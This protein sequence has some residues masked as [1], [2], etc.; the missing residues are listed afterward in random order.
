[1]RL[2]DR[3]RVRDELPRPPVG[4]LRRVVIEHVTGCDNG[5]RGSYLLGVPEKPIED[6]ILHDIHLQQHPS[7]KP[8]TKGDEFG[9]MRGVYPDAHMIDDIG[10]APA[11]ALWAHHV[12][13]LQLTDYEVLPTG[14][15]P[16]PTYAF[17]FEDMPYIQT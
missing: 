15:D 6:V 16:R 11:Y 10:D 8:V 5:P 4:T 12:R 7:V 17:L 14:A 9:E 3:G 1:M 13:G 2:E